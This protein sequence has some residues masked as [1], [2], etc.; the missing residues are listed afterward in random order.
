MDHTYL[1]KP[2]KFIKPVK[3]TFW[4]RMLKPFYQRIMY[5]MYLIDRFEVRGTEYLK[6]SVKSG[7]GV[8]LSANHCRYSDPFVMGEV[9]RTT[10]IFLYFCASWHLFCVNKKQTWV[11]RR[12][13]AMSI[14][15]EGADRDCIREC[16]RVLEEA[17]RP[18][19]L[20]PEGT[21]YRQND[22]LGPLQDGVSFIARLA[23]KKDVRPMVIH[24]V[25]IKYWFTEDP[26]PAIE[27]RLAALE[28][29]CHCHPK[30]GQSFV[31]RLKWIGNALLTVKEMEVFG[32]P[33]SGELEERQIALA[34]HICT[35]FEERYFGK[36][37]RVSL[38]ERLRLLR[39]HI[40][41]QFTETPQN[42]PEW[43]EL[44]YQIEDLA[45]VQQLFSHSWK[46]IDAWPSLERISETLMRLEEDLYDEEK[47]MAK[48]GVI[49]EF[50]EPIEVAEYMSKKSRG[51]GDPL[52]LEI[53]RRTQGLLDSLV[54]QG[55][56]PSWNA[57]TGP[58]PARVSMAE[59]DAEVVSEAGR[60]L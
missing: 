12:M 58:G 46:Y 6:E 18:L 53:A 41:K 34:N 23:Q 35:S 60:S 22:E 47:S 48:M 49:I 43:Y 54:Q 51:E 38:M 17:E 14:Y 57:P 55:P 9:M 26:R 8:L 3:T 5:N 21:F 24:P 4:S 11:L 1:A 32:S 56:P 19:V 10:N 31:E 33:Q 50:G 7:K 28:R 2:Y 29:R 30:M 52:T 27:K 59:D 20:F 16:Q 13:G 44:L 36:G 25:A 39:N 40:V 42:T 45:F 15:R 37:K